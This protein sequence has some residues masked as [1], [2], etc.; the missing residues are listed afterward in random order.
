MK[1]LKQA[2]LALALFAI[3]R[4]A[5]ATELKIATLAPQG[6]T[7]YNSLKN[8][9]DEIAAKTGGKVTVKLFGGGVE[10]DEKDVVRKMRMHQLSGAALTGMGMSLIDPEIRVLELPFLFKDDTQVDKVYS[11]MKDYFTKAYDQRGYVLLGWAEMGFV[12]IFSNK[13]IARK[14]D[15]KGM[16]MWMWEG[17]DLAKLMYEAMGVTPVPLSVT[18][19]LTSLQTNLIDGVYN[20]EL[21]AI[22]FQWQTKVT[23]LTDLNLVNGTGAILITKD[24]WNKLDAGQ[25]TIVQQIVEDTSRKLV[26]Q[27]RSE[28]LTSKQMLSQ[29]G[30]KIVTPDPKDVAELQTIGLDV[31]QKLVGK[32]YSQQL[33]DQ[34]LALLK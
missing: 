32:L 22:A 33:L 2:L 18:D 6:T 30:V 34:V 3:A 19:V 31:R 27:T 7:L 10:G 23:S 11:A 12:K 5:F 13:P 20:T 1:R 28:N 26:L 9:G 29:N 4:P 17:D 16:K 8:T 25:K 21:G 14:A 15:L 24:D